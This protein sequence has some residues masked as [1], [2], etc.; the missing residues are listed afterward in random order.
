M[1]RKDDVK[2]LFNFMIEMLKDEA[3]T[4]ENLSIKNE[5][6]E[7]KELLVETPKKDESIENILNVMKRVDE[8]EK[9]KQNIV[10][11]VPLEERDS[12]EEFEK[13]L[14]ESKKIMNKLDTNKPI[15][16][17]LTPNELNKIE[18]NKKFS[19]DTING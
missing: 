1:A 17:S 7:K 12:I 5:K 6:E 9:T 16:S 19:G 15:V 2:M 3:E 14:S 10:K 13:T 4:S 8:M 11:I 18:Q